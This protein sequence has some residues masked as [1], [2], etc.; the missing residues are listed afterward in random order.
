MRSTMWR[1]TDVI[2]TEACSFD[3][4]GSAGTTITGM[5]VYLAENV[6]VRIAYSVTCNDSWECRAAS[7]DR[8]IGTDRRRLILERQANG[9]WMSNG[10]AVDALA[11]LIDIDLGFTPATNTNAI[12]RL[13]LRVGDQAQITAIWLDDETWTFKPLKQRYERLNR[14]TYRYTSVDSGYQADLTVDEFGIVQTYPGLWEA[15][16]T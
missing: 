9:A 10:E 6:P 16:T 2:G 12:N 4:S 8:W 14:N 13:G 7:V 1:R 11:S 3:E 15:V 5:T